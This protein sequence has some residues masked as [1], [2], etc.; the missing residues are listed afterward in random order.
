MSK[1]AVATLV[2]VGVGVGALVLL[3]SSSK[4]SAKSAPPAPAPGLQFGQA[5]T[6]QGRSGWI[7]ATARV[8]NPGPIAPGATVQ[9]VFVAQAPPAVG[10]AQPP[11]TLV[12]MFAQMGSDM[13]TRV[14]LPQ[15]AGGAGNEDAI[16]AARADFGV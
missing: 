5:A 15:P 16:S 10:N 6:V 12:L 9:A 3:G 14:L 1:A 7:W 13:S 8:L 11:G 4:A 2:V